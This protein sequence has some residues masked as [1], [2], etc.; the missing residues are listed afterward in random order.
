MPEKR[1]PRAPVAEAPQ[2][3]V[4]EEQPVPNV[5]PAEDPAPPAPKPLAD[6]RWP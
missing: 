5:A 2:A 6:S 1:K 3:P 4:V